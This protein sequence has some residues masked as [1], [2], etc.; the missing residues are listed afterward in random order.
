MKL[1]FT[2]HGES[3]AT[4]R[5]IISNRNLPH[6]LTQTG[7][8]QAE[9]LAKKLTGKSITRIYTSPIPRAKETAEILSAVLKAPV[10]Y[11]DGLR[12][13]D[14]GVLEG[15]EDEAAWAEHNYWKEAWFM[16]RQLECGP[17][18]GETC[19]EVRERLSGFI[20]NLINDYGETDAEF[21]LVTHGALILFGL[22][23]VCTG[24]DQLTLIDHGLDHTAL[25]TTELQNGELVYLGCSIGETGLE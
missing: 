8:Q 12:E 4:T 22:L 17:Q 10:E 23:E 1:Y 5:R 2:R 20:G 25:I 19:D 7:R 18:D 24:V 16:G 6:P 11:A 14:C 3:E 15:R 21:L 9:A 13:P